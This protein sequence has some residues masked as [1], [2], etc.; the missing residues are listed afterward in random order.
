MWSNQGQ[1]E[2][3]LKIFLMAEPMFVTKNL[4]EPWFGVKG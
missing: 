2:N 1:A 4:D 3:L